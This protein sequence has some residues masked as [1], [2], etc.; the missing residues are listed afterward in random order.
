MHFMVTSPSFEQGGRIPREH[1]CDGTDSPPVLMIDHAPRGTRSF[2]LLM[3][4]ADAPDHPMTHWLVF[5]IP[6]ES[7]RIGD[8]R[9]PGLVGRNDHH[10]QGY[11]GPCPPHH[12]PD[13]R[14]AFTLFALD[15]ANLGLEPGA[16]RRDVELAMEGHVLAQTKLIGRYAR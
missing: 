4:D 8:D 12:H 13:H 10:F 3:E 14:Y 9:S 6:A 7:R 11:R 1:T 2:V 15:I 5:D 16:R